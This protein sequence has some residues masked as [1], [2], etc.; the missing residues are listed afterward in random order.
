VAAVAAFA[1]GLVARLSEQTVFAGTDGDVVL[2]LHVNRQ[3][4]TGFSV[5]AVP[6][7]AAANREPDS[8]VAGTFSWR[9]VAKRND[10]QGERLATVTTPPEPTLPPV[11]PDVSTPP[12]PPTSDRLGNLNTQPARHRAYRSGPPDRR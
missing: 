5:D 7:G 3:T 12:P 1:A 2:G 6:V 10:I 4:P 11:P 9:V 8:T